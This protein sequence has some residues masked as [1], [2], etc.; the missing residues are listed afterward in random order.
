MDG[1]YICPLKARAGNFFLQKKHVFLGLTPV[2]SETTAL[3]EIWAPNCGIIPAKRFFFSKSQKVTETG[4]Y[5]IENPL[6]DFILKLS[7]F[8]GLLKIPLV[9]CQVPLVATMAK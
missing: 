9:G 6:P 8:L 1:W 2:Y 3:R 5:A 4:Y 7:R